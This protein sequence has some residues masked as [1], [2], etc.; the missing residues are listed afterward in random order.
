MTVSRVFC[1][2]ADPTLAPLSKANG[3]GCEPRRRGRFRWVGG[4]IAKHVQDLAASR[5]NCDMRLSSSCHL[6]EISLCNMLLPLT[7]LRGDLFGG[8][9]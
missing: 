3:P 9:K 8:E 4:N 2:M 6:K 5:Q 1:P 7:M